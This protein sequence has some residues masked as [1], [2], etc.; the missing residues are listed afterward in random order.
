MNFAPPIP[1]NFLLPFQF[2]IYAANNR[3][4]DGFGAG[5]AS[6]GEHFPVAIGAVGLLILARESLP[7]Q[8]CVAVRAHLTIHQIP[9]N[10]EM[11]HDLQS[12]PCDTARSCM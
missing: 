5:A 11:N 10:Q 2:G 4:C 9:M 12:I 1:A 7:C 8:R 6:F 3:T